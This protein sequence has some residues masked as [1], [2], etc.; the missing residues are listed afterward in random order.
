VTP[1]AREKRESECELACTGF[2]E[3]L[4]GVAALAATLCGWLG[5]RIGRSMGWFHCSNAECVTRL[6]R[7]DTICPGCGGHIESDER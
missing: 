5:F 1:R 4:G 3:D 7:A 2:V 6:T